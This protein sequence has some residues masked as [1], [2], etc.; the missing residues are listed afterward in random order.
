[1]SAAGA[2][3]ARLV[4]AVGG[5]PAT[6][7]LLIGGLLVGIAGGFLLGGGLPASPE[8]SLA[9]T[10]AIYPCPNSGPAI[11]QAPSGQRM[12]VTGRSADDEWLRIQYPAPARS[13]AWVRT[14]Q[15]ALSGSMEDL[16]VVECGAETAVS[17]GP[18]VLASLTAIGS[19]VPTPPPT[20]TPEPTP[21]P[22]PTPAPTP[23]PPK[24]TAP[25]TAPPQTLPPPP[26]P[27][28]NPGPTYPGLR[29]NPDVIQRPS[30]IACASA[31]TTQILALIDDPDGV[32]PGSV[33]LHFTPP[34]LSEQ[35]TP[36]ANPSGDLR[37]FT[38]SITATINWPGPGSLTYY[39][40]ASDKLGNGSQSPT[41]T[42][43]VCL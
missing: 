37:T 20:P 5:A 9:G 8:P 27:I 39:V 26:T 14:S 10:L 4:S 15:I 11:L 23:K 33:V 28:P 12:L 42:V 41:G 30:I 21:E 13:E 19:F 35:T 32:N 3:L 25:P 36:M 34:G 6:G 7:A 43:T 24:P 31:N 40:T 38:A 22:T 1:M 17:P 29:D 18:S 16:P 2:W